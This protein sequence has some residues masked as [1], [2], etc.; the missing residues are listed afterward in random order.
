MAEAIRRLCPSSTGVECH[1]VT[2]LSPF[3]WTKG[4]FKA[5]RAIREGVCAGDDLAHFITATYTKMT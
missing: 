4:T 2:G 1:L 3:R 5:T